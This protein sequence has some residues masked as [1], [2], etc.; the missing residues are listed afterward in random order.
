MSEYHIH[1]ILV[2]STLIGLTA[3]SIG[4]TLPFTGLCPIPSK[5]PEPMNIETSQAKKIF[6]FPL[7]FIGN[8]GHQKAVLVN[9]GH[10]VEVFLKEPKTAEIVIGG[11]LGFN[12]YV[13]SK[14]RFYWTNE[15]NGEAYSTVN[16]KNGSPLEASVV[17][18]NLKYGTYREALKYRDGLFEV[19]FRI[20]IGSKS[21][22]KFE[23][24]G[25]ALRKVR[26]PT[27]VATIELT[28]SFLWFEESLTN[29]AYFA[30]P[31][32]ETN[33]T[34]HT[35]YYCTTTVLVEQNTIPSISKK[36]FKETFLRLIGDNGNP[37][38][39]QRPQ[40][41]QD[42]RPVVESFGILLIRLKNAINFPSVE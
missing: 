35:V 34:S 25:Q 21:S 19:L 31:G 12:L 42:N 11:V 16:G 40:V 23:K 8:H 41:P 1:L 33:E 15:T 4:T 27:Q 26:Q 9:T 3:A 36:Q 5:T 10:S 38:I 32:A 2:L 18:Y 39:N 14:T 24:F 13:Y 7:T 37:L 29:V 22:R 30:Y 17:Y 20:R 6:T 28:D